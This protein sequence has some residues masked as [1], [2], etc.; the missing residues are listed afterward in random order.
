VKKADYEIKKA[1]CKVK[2]R[3]IK[4]KADYKV[5]FYSPPLLKEADS[6]AK[7]LRQY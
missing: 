3:T 7:K 1:D 6:K 2:R 5:L 4:K